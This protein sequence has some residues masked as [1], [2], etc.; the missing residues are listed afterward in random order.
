MSEGIPEGWAW[1]S[2]EEIG[3]LYCGQSPSV[4]NV[5]TNGEGTPYVTGPDQWDGNQIRAHKWTT[6][7]KRLVPENCLFIT[8]KGAGVGTLFPGIPC[9]I[10]RDIYAFKPANT[11]SSSFVGLALQQNI[12]EIIKQAAGLIPGLSKEH[13]LGHS[14]PLPPFAEQKRIV[15][16]VEAL[17]AHVNAARER[18]ARVPAILKR[19]R[20]AVLAEAF[21]GNLT[22]DWKEPESKISTKEFP[23]WGDKGRSSL[24]PKSNGLNELPD[25]WI[26]VTPEEV[27]T[28]IVDCPH[29][30]PRWA[31][32]GIICLRTT[33]FRPGFLDLSEVRYVSEATYKKRITRLKPRA[34]DV[35]YSRE[36]GILGI[37]CLIPPGLIACLGQRMMLFR[38]HPDCSPEYFMHVMNSPLIINRVQELTGGTA[39]PHLNV[40]DIKKFPIPLPPIFEQKEIVRQVELYFRLADAIEKRVALTTCRVEKL[41]QAILA[42]AFRGELVPTEAELARQ[43]GR[44]Y[45]PASLLVERIQAER[46]K[47]DSEKKRKST[48]SLRKR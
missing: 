10:G 46:E 18:L 29:S 21:S 1:V 27:T 5:N 17:L 2:L 34:G 24:S 3:H 43:E 30:T 16:K 32:S 20:Q 40:G 35:I 15:A 47:E 22:A 38:V 6:D 7:P 44:D 37:A 4:K 25:D 11:V 13:L 31:D 23:R 42:K 39:S 36:G 12:R 28:E 33:N 9:A 26:W 14:I 8:V 48:R 45:E 41:T 19:F